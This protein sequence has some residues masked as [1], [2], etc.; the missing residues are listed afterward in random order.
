MLLEKTKR[1]SLRY[2]FFYALR[3]LRSRAVKPLSQKLPSDFPQHYDPLAAGFSRFENKFAKSTQ[4]HVTGDIRATD[5]AIWLSQSSPLATNNYPTF[6]ELK[7]HSRLMSF[8]E[9]LGI[10]HLTA[11]QLTAFPTILKGKD[12]TVVAPTGSGKTLCYILPILQRLYEIHDA[13]RE[14]R[15]DAE[16]W[17]NPLSHVRPCIILQPS[18]DLCYQVSYCFTFLKKKCSAFWR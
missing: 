5:D 12:C 3:E 6:K 10:T 17:D 14:S 8:L 4:V 7:V 16:S 2:V 18:R 11:V 15:N 9:G 13:V 1:C